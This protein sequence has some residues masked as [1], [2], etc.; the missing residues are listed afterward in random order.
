MFITS[1]YNPN[2]IIVPNYFLT[3]Y[4]DKKSKKEN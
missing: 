2:L 3:I 1:M 4:Y